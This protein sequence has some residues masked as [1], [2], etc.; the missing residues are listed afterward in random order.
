MNPDGRR[1]V[2]L[3]SV[4]PEAHV[5]MLQA[6]KSRGIPVSI[7]HHGRMT[8]RRLRSHPVVVIVD[9]VYG[10]ALD[11]MSI[12]CLNSARASCTVLGLH[13][14]DLGRFAGELDELVVDGFCR[15]GEWF[16]IV[17]MAAE[18]FQLAAAARR[19]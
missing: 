5:M 12:A 6:L 13:D 3:L 11:R 19:I 9:L 1:G 15:A 17:E 2:L 18:S 16:P 14:G 4:L 10:A 7:A 8:L